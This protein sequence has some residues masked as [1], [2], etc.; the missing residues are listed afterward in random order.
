MHALSESTESLRT[1]R[2]L[3][4]KVGSALLVDD[5]GGN[6]RR[7]WLEAFADD[8]AALKARG[9]EMVIVTSGAV[10]SG[11][12]QLGLTGRT[13][14]LEEKQA[15]AATGQIRL[16]HAWQEAFARHA[17]SVAQILLTAEDTEARQRH[18]NARAT[19]H[20]LLRLS[21]IPLINEN[22]T[23]ATDEIKFGDNDRLAARVSQMISADTLV[24]LSDI[25]GLYTADPKKNPE[26][27][28]IAR[29]DEITPEIEDMAGP[30]V[31]G[32][33]SGGMVTK[34][35]AARIATGAGCR[36]AITLGA[37][38]H[39]LAAMEN[40]AAATWFMPK[41]NPGAA[42]KQWIAAHIQVAGLISI[43]DG[44]YQALLRGKSLLP[45][46]VKSIEGIFER[47]DVVGVRL[48]DGRE[49]AR[50]LAA[51]GSREANL[52][53]GRQSAEIEQILGEQGGRDVL[54]HRDDLVMHG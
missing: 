30:P 34:L 43:D 5:A 2:R 13:I 21:A 22:D 26:A 37:K 33:S 51:Y 16:A 44:A 46:G 27:R 36:M 24:L 40:G 39:P 38:M 20:T 4:V 7:E 9:M 48:S 15:A 41:G 11:R 28:L 1:A 52:I 45:A 17:L 50:G 12:R 53:K 10:A 25:D 8:V 47:G 54:I 23:V 14:K 18:L 35:L 3:V 31:P 42:R 19:I 32:M 29:V 6:I 49:I